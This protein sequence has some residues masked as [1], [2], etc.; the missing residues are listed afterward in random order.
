MLVAPDGKLAVIGQTTVNNDG[1]IYRLTPA[2]AFDPTFDGDG[3]LGVDSGGIDTLFDGLLEPDGNIVA[4]GASKLDGVVYRL[5]G[6]PFPLKV[7]R[8]G[9]GAGSVVSDPRGIDCGGTCTGTYDV[10]TRVTLAAVPAQ[11]STFAGWTGGG[12]PASPVCRVELRSAVNV[13]A[14]FN[15]NPAPAATATPTS[16]P[17]PTHRQGHDDQVRDDHERHDGA[18]DQRR[19][20]LQPQLP[21]RQAQ[22]RARDRRQARHQRA[23][24]AVGGCG[25]DADDHPRQAHRR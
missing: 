24:H 18:Q 9:S 19:Q 13:T 14:T 21:P 3:A 15:A 8:N 20:A 16:A 12:C 2:G 25:G 6:D 7:S 10:G 5:L 23:L 1:A 4:A 22:D 11:G 17:K